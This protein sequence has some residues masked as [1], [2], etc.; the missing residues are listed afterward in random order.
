MP[1]VRLFAEWLAILTLTLALSA[2]AAAAGLTQRIDNAILDRALVSGASPSSADIVIV[3]IDER[4]LASEGQWPWPR[5]KIAKLVDRIGESSPRAIL[6]DVLFIEPSDAEGDAAL[7]ASLARSGKVALPIGHAPARDAS[8]G[9]SALPP[10]REFARPALAVGHVGIQPDDDGIVRRILPNLQ[11]AGGDPVPH[12][13]LALQSRLGGP[14]HDRS[15]SEGALQLRMAGSYRTVPASSVLAGDLPAQFLAGKVVIVGATAQGLGDNFSVSSS[16]GSMMSGSELLANA[17]QDLRE[18]GFVRPVSQGAALALLAG[19]IGLLFAAFW[20]LRPIWCLW[21]A[22]ACAGASLLLAWLLAV[23]G[24][25]WFAPG[26][27]LLGLLIAYPLWGW[28]RLAAINAYLMTKADRLSGEQASSPRAADGFDSVARAVNRLDFL[29]DELSERRAFLGR[30]VESTPDALFVFDDDG[31]LLTLN[32]RAAAIMGSALAELEGSSVSDL[33]ARVAG[34]LAH[35]GG[36]LHLGDG[37]I[38]VITRSMGVPQAQWN[39]IHLAM[40]TDVTEQRRAEAE[41]RHALEFLSHDMRSPQV[42]I[43]GLTSGHEG[44]ETPEARFSRIRRH[45]RRTLELADNFVELARLGDA[46]L[47][48]TVF[49][50]GALADEAADRAFVM[51]RDHGAAVKT[52]YP[53]E[54]VFARCDGAVLSR[55]LD[56]LVGNALKYGAR[57]VTLTVGS[58]QSATSIEIAD[59]GP[60]LPPERAA[61]P[62]LRFGARSGEGK[63]GAGLGLAFVAAAIARH[64]GIISCRSEAGK[65]TCFRIELPINGG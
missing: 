9:A 20:M 45:A 29:V 6:L 7:A 58:G 61:D 52:A 42:A 49:D 50:L 33:L 53:D 57:H 11:V 35:E 63:G 65:G 28:R 62:F 48:M 2:W 43:L 41:R 13:A 30:V 37:R 10:L 19:F 3:A 36:E 40:L 18:G 38:F 22:L 16:A 51:A 24:G 54:P 21:T 15:A 27:V 55:V 39:D 56:N 12:L 1:R 8:S 34:E 25:Q 23:H 64:D 26:P 44:N 60:G 46:P 31:K 59:D 4:S 5:S 47:D 17:L 14:A 32:R